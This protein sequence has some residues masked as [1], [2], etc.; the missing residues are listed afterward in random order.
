M[1]KTRV[2]IIVVLPSLVFLLF[3][4][5]RISYQ[6]PCDFEEE[7]QV[8]SH[9]FVELDVV[10]NEISRLLYIFDRPNPKI[11]SVLK[12]AG[13]KLAL[14]DACPGIDKFRLTSGMA[15]IVDERGKET[16][17]YISRMN[18]QFRLI[19]GL[20]VDINSAPREVLVSLP[21]FSSRI[22]DAII[23]CRSIKP[24]SRVDELLGIKGVGRVTLSKI[25]NYVEC[26]PTPIRPQLLCSINQRESF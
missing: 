17:I 26:L 21:H 5:Y 20:P 14:L 15:V 12:R 19:L 8:Q 9:L 6:N 13:K 3:R 4:T 16:K 18:P 23:A 10:N 7:T 1:F 2:I 25:R 24:F 11:S 22:V